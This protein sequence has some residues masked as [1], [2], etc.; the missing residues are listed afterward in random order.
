ML[1]WFKSQEFF[2]A[3]TS[4][5]LFQYLIFLHGPTGLFCDILHLLCEPFLIS[6]M[7]LTYIILRPTLLPAGII[8]IWEFPTKANWPNIS[9]GDPITH[10]WGIGISQPI[11]ILLEFDIHLTQTGE[12]IYYVGK[13]QVL[14]N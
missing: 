7:F 6:S 1:N 14:R 12:C 3:L 11:K 2:D 8:F 9:T 5:G 4:S 13:E 10:V